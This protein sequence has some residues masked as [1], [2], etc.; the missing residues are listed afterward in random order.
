TEEVLEGVRV[1]VGLW[2]WTERREHAPDASRGRRRQSR[3]SSGYLKGG[4]NS[5]GDGFA[6]FE[7]SISSG[8]LEGV[9]ERV[10][11]VEQP[12]A[13]ARAQVITDDRRLDRDRSGDEIHQRFLVSSQ[14]LRDVPLRPL[15]QR[16][17]GDPGRLERLD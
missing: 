15:G 9:A 5:P 12:P 4:G 3:P 13:A 1:A 10:P 8:R 17:V 6:V 2:K 14:D 16:R 11:E 7:L